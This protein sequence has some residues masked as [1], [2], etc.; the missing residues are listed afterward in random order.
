LTGNPTVALTQRATKATAGVLSSLRP[1]YEYSQQN[2]K[3]L[4]YSLPMANFM[5]IQQMWN[6]LGQTLPEQ[7]ERKR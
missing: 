7:S 4:Q 2:L 5:G 6:V 3:D 1:D